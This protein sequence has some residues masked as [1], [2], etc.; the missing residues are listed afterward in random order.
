MFETPRSPSYHVI[1]LRHGESVGNAAGYYQGQSDFPLSETGVLQAQALAQRWLAEKASFTQVISSP[2]ARARQTA[3]I[4][5]AALG[6][7][8]LDLQP[9]WMERDNG[10]LAGLRP[11]EA[12]ERFPRPAFFHPYM[13]IGQTG[14]SQMELYLRAGSAVQDLLRRPPGRYLVVSHGGLLNM[15]M[16]VILGIVPQ[17]NFHGP[18]FRFR[19]TAFATLTYLP[20][21]H[22]WR[23]EGLNDQGHWPSQES[24]DQPV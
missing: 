10:Q 18:R 21:A 9:L 16:Y 15:V 3:E 1:L 14:E 23:L 5:A 7:L 6:D 17:A 13:P 24:M 4:I 12:A 20:E 8:P 22:I 2:L 11:Q 19:N